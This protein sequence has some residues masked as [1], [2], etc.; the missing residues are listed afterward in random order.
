MPLRF[1]M[2]KSPEG[3]NGSAID[4]VD[5]IFVWKMAYPFDQ[6]GKNLMI[7][8]LTISRRLIEVD[9]LLSEGLQL[10]AGIFTLV[11]RGT[12]P[13]NNVAADIT[14]PVDTFALLIS[15]RHG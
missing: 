9:H 8:A 5:V 13:G 11:F 1:R 3:D 15:L 12:A 4:Q 10:Y 7:T 2:D 6:P 14:V